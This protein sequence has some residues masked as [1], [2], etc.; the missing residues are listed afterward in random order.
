MPG[1]GPPPHTH[2]R[3]DETL[4]IHEG[5]LD[6]YQDN[7]TI[8]CHP[9]DVMFLPRGRR[10]YFRIISGNPAKYT[11]VCTPGGFDRFFREAAEEFKKP[12]PDFPTK[13]SCATVKYAETYHR[14]H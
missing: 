9:G 12:N 5:V 2:T 8:T 14:Q 1:D 11:V 13:D 7:Q 10:H 6:I 4:I 3:E